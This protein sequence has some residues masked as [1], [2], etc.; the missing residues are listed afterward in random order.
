MKR[1]GL[2]YW[3]LL[4]VLAIVVGIWIY[5]VTSGRV[6]L[7]DQ[8]TRAFVSIFGST[9]YYPFFTFT[10][11]LGSKSFLIPFVIVMA[12]VLVFLYKRYLQAFMF[13]FGTLF[14]W[15]L[16]HLIKSVVA[17]ERPSIDPSLDAIGTSFPSGHAMISFICYSLLLYFLLGR[18]KGKGLRVSI[19]IIIPLLI[20]LIGIGRYLINVHYLTDVMAGYFFG[21][22]FVVF[23]IWFYKEIRSQSVEQGVK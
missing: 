2:F 7:V 11:H 17:R 21:Y 9:A 6:P 10:T 18:I 19:Q 22:L 20:L 8:W 1:N 16:N 15:I 14:G 4:A 23:W 13:A 3:G 5:D 12:V